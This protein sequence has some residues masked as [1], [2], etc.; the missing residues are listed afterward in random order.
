MPLQKTKSPHDDALAAAD[1]PH[2]LSPASVTL[3]V[4][5]PNAAARTAAKRLPSQS[6]LN[7][8]AV[9][10]DAANSLT[11]A[12]HTPPTPSMLPTVYNSAAFAV[13]DVDALAEA[14]PDA[15]AFTRCHP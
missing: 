7:I 15:G 10:P 12:D 3:A 4:A 8:A 14:V 2:S 1:F 6:A 9:A 5:I 13:P 11:A